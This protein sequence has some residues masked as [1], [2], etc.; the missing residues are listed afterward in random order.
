[1]LPPPSAVSV[2]RFHQIAVHYLLTTG[3][4]RH[5]TQV[6]T[7]HPTWLPI[8]LKVRCLSKIAH[9][10]ALSINE[11]SARAELIPHSG[12]FSGRILVYLDAV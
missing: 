11:L 8:L 4:L 6:E 9:L 10:V 1:M 12:T 7:E 3:S 5:I 2:V